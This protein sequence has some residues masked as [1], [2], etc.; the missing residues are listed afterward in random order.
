MANDT[1]GIGPKHNHFQP[2]EP[3]KPVEQKGEFENQSVTRH[4]PQKSQLNKTPSQV[5]KTSLRERTVSSHSIKSHDM[6]TIR[7]LAGEGKWQAVASAIKTHVRNHE[8]LD[9]VVSELKILDKLP[10]DIQNTACDQFSK[11]QATRVAN[12]FASQLPDNPREELSTLMVLASNPHEHD[13]PI[14]SVSRL[15]TDTF[16][17]KHDLSEVDR[18]KVVLS[19]CEQTYQIAE[20]RVNQLVE[21]L[22]AEGD[23]TLN[24]KLDEY[25]NERTIEG[26]YRREAMSKA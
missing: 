2:S 17:K 11:I 20:Q 9:Q 4:T 5:P 26:R 18:Q 15:A 16:L 7:H 1:S 8:Q 14:G 12:I 13:S 23:E 21:Q 25:Q 10:A 22:K 24:K 3:Q 19:T 6:D